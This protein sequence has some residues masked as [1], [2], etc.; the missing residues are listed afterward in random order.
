MVGPPQKKK[1]PTPFFCENIKALEYSA[2]EEPR[3][4]NRGTFRCG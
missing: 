2:A 1:E 4:G 3:R